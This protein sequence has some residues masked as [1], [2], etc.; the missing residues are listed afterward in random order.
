MSETRQDAIVR[1]GKLLDES[2]TLTG[3]DAGENGRD[4]NRQTLKGANQM[5][6]RFTTDATTDELRAE[7]I[8]SDIDSLTLDQIDEIVTACWS[9]FKTI[10]RRY[11][12]ARYA[13][14]G[15]VWDEAT[16]RGYFTADEDD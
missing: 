15:D 2:I 9:D 13:N 5:A 6:A 10:A 7:L 4:K 16:D 11:L 1:I 14:D 12:A 8:D 3:K